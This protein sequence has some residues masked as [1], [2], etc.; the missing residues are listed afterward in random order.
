[1]QEIG[2]IWTFKLYPS[3]FSTGF[4]LNFGW[5]KKRLLL[6][7]WWSQTFANQTRLLYPTHQHCWLS[8]Q[9]SNN[10]KVFLHINIYVKLS[11]I[12]SSNAKNTFIRRTF[13]TP[14]YRTF[15]TPKFGHLPLPFANWGPPWVTVCNEKWALSQADDDIYIMMSVCLSV[16]HEIW[17]LPPLSLL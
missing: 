5:K 16:C 12:L 13:V 10:Q 8:N 3:S 15:A 17:S 4:G 2:M 14:I 9:N 1:M 7:F 6:G 11:F